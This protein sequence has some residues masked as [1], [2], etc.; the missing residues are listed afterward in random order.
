MT[1][2]HSISEFLAGL[3]YEESQPVLDLEP[4]SGFIVHSAGKFVATIQWNEVR[5]I[6]AFRYQGQRPDMM[7]LVFRL[8]DDTEIETKEDSPRWVELVDA[9]LNSFPSIQR[10]W[11]LHVE[12]AASA[13]GQPQQRTI[14]FKCA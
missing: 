8:K 1:L 10:D 6:V 5:E 4:V 3:R 2:R 13:D 12:A 9:M 11:Y 14:L 7:A